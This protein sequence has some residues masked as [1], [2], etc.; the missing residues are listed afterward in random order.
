MKR[1]VAA[2][3]LVALLSVIYA[4]L[5]YAEDIVKDKYAIISNESTDTAN[6]ETTGAFSSVSE[7]SQ[8]NVTNQNSYKIDCVKPINENITSKSLS[9]KANSKMLIEAVS[10]A[11]G[12]T[13]V[14]WTWNIA[15]NNYET[16]TAT[17][18]SSGIKVN[19]WVKTSD[20]NMS[21]TDA[22]KIKNE[23]DNSIYTKVSSVFGQPS[24]VDG[25]GKVNILCFDIKDGFSGSGSYVGGYFDPS[26]LYPFDSYTNDS[27]NYMEVF[28]IDTYPAMG[29]T[30]TKDV[31]KCYDT[32]AHEFQHMVNWNQNI[33]IEN[34][35]ALIGDMD[36][37]LNEGLSEAASQVYS[38][39]V[40]G[41]R[42][43]YYNSSST[44][45]N[46][47]SLLRWDY[48]NSLDNYSLSYLFMEYLKIQVGIGDSVFTE[49][50][51]ST[52]NNY[53]AVEQVIKK[54]IDPDLTFKQFM[55]N[56]RTALLL[57]NSAGPYGFKGVSGFN[58]ISTKIYTGGAVNLYGG[59]AVVV[60]ANAVTNKINVP[61][62][63]GA[64]INY[65]I[66]TDLPR[67]V[68]NN[69]SYNTSRTIY[70]FYGTGTLNGN[71]FT[72]GKTVNAEGSH[73]L[74]IT[75]G[76]ITTINFTIDKTPPIITIGSYNT[77]KTNQS[78][79][80]TASANEGTLN[81]ENHT[82]SENGSFDFIATDL[83]GNS[84]TKTVTISNII[85]YIRA[86][87]TTDTKI[88]ALDLLQLKKFL[89][90]QVSL[91]DAEKLAADVTGDGNVDALDLLQ[92]KKYLLGQVAL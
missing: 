47:S 31:T 70:Y 28:Y 73:S 78:I 57:K 62:Y 63:K 56:F 40:S 20:Y 66:I 49:V 86:D 60:A 15:N 2:V 50:T 71:S 35:N 51:Q 88:D 43:D 39:Q 82:F 1:I 84:T 27:S 90:G 30:A 18:K 91:S 75:N 55:T 4:P 81:F 14:F 58:S 7:V 61:L 67:G 83:A 22:D 69:T 16:V 52:Y 34:N 89:L 13:K 65:F 25:N 46:G 6:A 29:T 45:K 74:A 59:G 12:D 21:T 76:T 79:T 3:M 23:F 77:G 5:T 87:I 68:V 85:K 9:L 26:D 10:Y 92:L 38:G 11:V 33:F 24:D 8:N 72:S 41:S 53:R 54:Y 37:W 32:L 80:V 48:D 36:V 42:I 19:V 64:N 44:I 17:L